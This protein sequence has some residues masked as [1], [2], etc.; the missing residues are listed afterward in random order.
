VSFD[1][2]LLIPLKE[3]KKM[4]GIKSEKSKDTRHEKTTKKLKR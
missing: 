3:T 2:P 1:C 4:G